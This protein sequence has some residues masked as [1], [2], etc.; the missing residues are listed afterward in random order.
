MTTAI[1]ASGAPTVRRS[2]EAMPES[3][4]E[5][6]SWS[7]RQRSGILRGPDGRLRA[8]LYAQ[9]FDRA[10]LEQ[11]VALA[12]R[13]RSAEPEGA[14]RAALSRALRGRAAAL[15]FQQ[16]STRT[17][18]SFSLAA[19]GIGMVTEEIRSPERASLV[20]GETTLDT[21]LTL[22][23]LSDC[24]I[25]RHDD[26]EA[27]ERFAWEIH[28]RGLPT[29]LVNA[30]SGADQHPTQALLDIATLISRFDLSRTDPP[31]T[32]G[33]VGDLRRARTA[34]S[35]SYLLALYPTVRQVFIAPPDLAMGR[36]LVTALEERGVT[37]VETTEFDAVIEELD[38]VY[39][40]RMQDEYGETSET[41]RAL[42]G[43]Y[44]LSSERA[45]RLRPHAC[46]LHPLPRREELPIELDRD[47]RTRH[48]EAV[49]RGRF[50][51]MALLLHMFGKDT[52]DL[53]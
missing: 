52:T 27:I 44:R 6:R 1:R 17:F 50:L 48:W 35:L 10:L 5:F 46:V 4:E 40:T 51:R 26:P 30:G 32:V 34:R 15:Y 7:P 3:Y 21:L 2:D 23:E 29:R 11:L 18:V 39:L 38:A 8:L 12:E 43:N 37:L 16:P 25:L 31:L 33:I 22:A 20:K 19:Q 41:V 28:D 9:Q 49:H 45:A 13:I 36:D 53:S 47:P 14:F 42:F 24:V